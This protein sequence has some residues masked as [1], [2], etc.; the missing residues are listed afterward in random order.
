MTGDGAGADEIA[1][2]KVA[3]IAGVMRDHLRQRPVHLRK[4]ALRQAMRGKAVAAHCLG[5]DIGF[6]RDVESAF[7]AILSVVKMGKRSGIAFGP[8]KSGS[9]KGREA[10]AVTT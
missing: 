8:G 3:A 5:E 2:F 1:D 6:E 4:R 10:S 9:A 7:G